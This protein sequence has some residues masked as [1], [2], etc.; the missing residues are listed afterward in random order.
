MESDI[1][2]KKRRNRKKKDQP[3]EMKLSDWNKIDF[4]KIQTNYDDIYYK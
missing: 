2:G 1:G 4:A 3:L